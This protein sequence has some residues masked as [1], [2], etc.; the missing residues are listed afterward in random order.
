LW[1][2]WQPCFGQSTWRYC[3]QHVSGVFDMLHGRRGY[4]SN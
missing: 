1:N 3:V 4:Y 2:V